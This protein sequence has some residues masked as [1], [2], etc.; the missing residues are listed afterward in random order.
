MDTFRRL[1][2]V[3]PAFELLRA[4]PMYRVLTI[5]LLFCC[6][7]LVIAQEDDVEVIQ[8]GH[9][10]HGEVFNKGPR[11]Q[12]YLMP[13]TGAIKFEVSSD[14]DQ[15]QKFVEQGIGQ[16]HGFWHFEAERSFRQAAMLDPECAIAY[17]GMAFA[18]GSNDDRAKKFSKQAMKRIENA[19]PRERLYIEAL[20][21]FINSDEKRKKKEAA[22]VSALENIVEE[23]PDDLEAKAFLGY[24][25]YRYRG[26]ADKTHAE[27]DVILD[28]VLAKEKNHPVH[29][30][31]IHL[32]DHKSPQRAL[33]SAAK[34]GPSADTIAHM[35]HMCGHIFSRVKRYDDAS[36]F[37]EASARVDHRHMMHDRVLPDQIH[38]FAHNNE[39]LIRNLMHVGRIREAVDLAK[40]MTELPRH[41]EYNMLDKRKSASYGRDRLIDVL[42]KFELWEEAIS[43]ADTP[44]LEPTD[45]NEEQLKR[46]RLLGEAYARSDQLAAAHDVVHE[47]EE[48]L[49]RVREE[50][51]TE[52]EAQEK[53]DEK[54][55][56]EAE[57][58][59]G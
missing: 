58:K 46:L 38:N 15:V 39:W 50:E 31:R 23:H 45:D 3:P 29:H 47:L 13:G 10:K 1:D 14:V 53:L 16:L 52:E 19:S 36:W 5:C 40:N 8:A 56:K 20:D 24:A 35:W 55:E 37:Q 57:K 22:F 18:N 12:A 51:P 42:N 34:C 41:P 32:W 43:F 7:T 21:Q 25:L 2:V 44:Y 54:E 48:H 30:Y 17:W 6:S 9:S 27:V 26:S 11:Q 28:Q 4:N 33:D 49:D 59:E